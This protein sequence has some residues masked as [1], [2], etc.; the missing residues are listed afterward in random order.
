MTRKRLSCMIVLAGI[1]VAIPFTGRSTRSASALI[2]GLSNAFG[3]GY[4]ASSRFIDKSEV[5]KTFADAIL[6]QFEYG[7][8]LE[9]F[10]DTGSN[11]GLSDVGKEA[12]N[13][14]IQQPA[15]AAL[16]YVA[17][18]S[19]TVSFLLQTHGLL[20]YIKTAQAIIRKFCDHLSTQG[21]RFL[22]GEYFDSRKKLS[23]SSTFQQLEQIHPGIIERVI[24]S[25]KGWRGL[26]GVTEEDKRKLKTH[27]EFCYQSWKLATSRDRQE[28]IRDYILSEVSAPPPSPVKTYSIAGRVTSS[29]MG[30][31]GVTL[32]LSGSGIFSRTTITDRNG[33]YLFTGV[34]IGSYT[35]KPTKAG[36]SFSPASRQIVILDR[37]IRGQDFS[38]RATRGSR[39]ATVLVMDVSGSMGWRWKGGVKIES[40]KQAALQFIEQVANEPRPPGAVHEIAVVT[41]SGDAH[42][43]LPLTSSYAQ[44]KR[45][46]IELEPIASTNVGAGL[47]TAL[48]ELEKVPRAQRF[49]ILLSDGKSNTG[50]SKPQVLSGPVVEA[51]RKG[52]CI[53]TVAFGDPGDIDEKFLR[54]IAAG[55]GCGIYSYASTSF[56]L[57]GTYVKVRHMTL[58][59]KQIVDFTSKGM[60]VIT[61]PGSAIS[62]GAFKLIRAA[63]E[64]HYTL[65][66]SEGGRMQAKLVDP[67]GRTVTSGYP[68]A[69]IYSGTRFSHMTV[70]SPKQGIWRVSAVPQQ[71]FP[72]QVQYYGVVSSRPGAVIPFDLPIF[73]IGDWCIPWP[74]LPT[75]LI[76]TI[77]VA[78]FAL[79][80]YQQLIVK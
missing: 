28:A 26:A 23:S 46:I 29:G 4:L 36:Y 35:V 14:L 57:F 80:L 37:D 22:L 27:L 33:Y 40:A 6:R 30:L 64:L 9:A 55:S 19:F 10:V 21:R 49:I 20:S 41:F 15:M 44:A 53:H 34:G 11:A 47:T 31:S 51:K 76:V 25:C 68:G 77:S 69:K 78:V 18:S 56:E 62:L 79:L 48:R 50:L 74:D 16:A 70:F 61:L 7:K 72:A 39:T 8:K 73:C 58:G 66:W 32:T 2:D 43:A 12:I 42:L 63:Q 13:H 38:A 54:N 5:N 75:P 65:A 24:V 1:V 60:R 71:R 59:S 3:V 45:V 17:Q 52:I 67:A